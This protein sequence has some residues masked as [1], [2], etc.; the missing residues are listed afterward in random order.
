MK[1]VH[2]ESAPLVGL[3]SVVRVRIISI[4]F[5]GIN[6]EE[7]DRCTSHVYVLA[8]R[9]R[10]LTFFSFWNAASATYSIRS[11]SGAHPGYTSE[12][13]NQRVEAREVDLLYHSGC[14]WCTCIYLYVKEYTPRDVLGYHIS[15]TRISHS[16]DVY[17][18][19]EEATKKEIRQ[20]VVYSKV[21]LGTSCKLFLSLSI[22]VSF[23]SP[24]SGYLVLQSNSADTTSPSQHF[25]PQ[26]GNQVLCSKTR[27]AIIFTTWNFQTA[28]YQSAT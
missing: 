12:L 28:C 26:M 11:N 16:C 9:T 2:G 18:A 21:K 10:A 14:C 24:L 1:V 20:D 3:L 13:Y 7:D 17:S 15:F 8:Q 22:Y 23:Q 5:A 27:T 19:A 4:S 25:P 6:D